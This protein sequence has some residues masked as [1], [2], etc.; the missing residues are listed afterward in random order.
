[1]KGKLMLCPYCCMNPIIKATC[2]DPLCQ[3]KHQRKLNKDNW[4]KNGKLWNGKR[5]FL[6]YTVITV[7]K[8]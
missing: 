7:K 8:N 2:G 1:M 5:K 4:L 3:F 6:Q